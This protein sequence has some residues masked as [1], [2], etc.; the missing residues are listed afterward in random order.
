MK[1]TLDGKKETKQLKGGKGKLFVC[2]VVRVCECVFLH[3]KTRTLKFFQGWFVG[4]C[5]CCFGCC[6]NVLCLVGFSACLCVCECVQVEKKDLLYSSVSNIIH[7]TVCQCSC[8][9]FLFYY[10]YFHFF[11]FHHLLHL[12]HSSFFLRKLV[13]CCWLCSVAAT[14]AAVVFDVCCYSVYYF[15]SLVRSYCRCSCRYSC[16]CPCS[17]SL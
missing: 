11:I 16:Y 6:S 17:C 1:K 5:D 9:V 15:N 4:C 2:L 10:F 14:G 8:G 13:Y 7:S 3:F 12:L